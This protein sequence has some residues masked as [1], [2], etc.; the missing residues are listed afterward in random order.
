MNRAER[1]RKQKLRSTHKGTRQNTLAHQASLQMAADHFRHG[2][3]QDAERLYRQVIDADPRNAA[4]HH[5]LG[6]LALQ[7]NHLPHACELLQK[8]VKLAP[9]SASAHCD[10]GNAYQACGDL[11][12]AVECFKRALSLNPDLYQLHGNI[13]NVQKEQ[14]DYS[15]AIA[16]YLKA[17]EFKPDFAEAHFNLGHVYSELGETETAVEHYLQALEINP[18][19]AEAYRSLVTLKALPGDD[20]LVKRM[21]ALATSDTMN[22]AERA[23]L[24][25]A[26]SKVNERLGHDDNCFAHLARG[27]A[28]RKK[29]L[30]YA[31]ENDRHVYAHIKG[32]FENLAEQDFTPSPRMEMSPRPIFIL[33]MPR[34]GTSLVEQILA[35]HSAVYGAG[36]LQALKRAVGPYLKSWDVDNAARGIRKAYEK[37][38]HQLPTDRPVVSDK[39]PLNAML[40]GFI[41]I[42]MPEAKIVHTCRDPRAVCW[43]NFKT[44]FPAPALGYT[45]DLEDVAHFYKLYEDMMAFW[46]DLF[47]GAI[48]D[49]SYEA[50]TENQEAETR[51]LLDHCELSWEDR[52]LAFH[53]TKRAVKTASSSQVRKG[54]YKGSSDDWRRYERHLGPMLDILKGPHD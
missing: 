10:L 8:A 34:S 22:E 32:L 51:K 3:Y 37:V 2:R 25:F 36:E 1:R 39:M 17:L 28:L 27:N 35:S 33:G 44:Y 16:S 42:A 31:F 46:K 47:P 38:L 7:F 29:I 15:A 30:G 49:L 26:L 40:I 41:R 13:A 54:L 19:Y 43:S 52:C 18:D 4:A 53:Q 14:G 23:H 11:T 21:A 50:L 9:D 5:G 48:Y 24:E 45:C 12:A 6:V 20:P